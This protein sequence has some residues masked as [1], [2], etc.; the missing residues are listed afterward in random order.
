MLPNAR[1]IHRAYFAQEVAPNSLQLLQSLANLRGF[2]VVGIDL[3]GP[4][5]VPARVGRIVTLGIGHADVEMVRGIVG[6]LLE[7]LLQQVDG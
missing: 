4:R 6:I 2:R 3:Q 5:K 1:E 7:R